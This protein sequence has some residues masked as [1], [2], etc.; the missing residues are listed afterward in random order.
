MLGMVLPRNRNKIFLSVVFIFLFFFAVRICQVSHWFSLLLLAC[1]RTPYLYVYWLLQSH[2]CRQCCIWKN[3]IQMW[4]NRE[5]GRRSLGAFSPSSFSLK[6]LCSEHRQISM[7]K[8]LSE[9]WP[10]G[11]EHCTLSLFIPGNGK[12]FWNVAF[13]RQSH[14]EG[15]K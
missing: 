15:D 3:S 2:S 4:Q 12:L 1:K 8:I 9:T 7:L 5:D 11:T 10:A 13:S 6:F 14:L